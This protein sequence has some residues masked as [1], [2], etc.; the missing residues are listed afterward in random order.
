MVLLKPF[1]SCFVFRLHVRLSLDQDSRHLRT[2][3]QEV[4]RELHSAEIAARLPRVA[5]N[6]RHPTH[7]AHSA[8][9]ICA[10]GHQR[11]HPELSVAGRCDDAARRG[12]KDLLPSQ[13]NS[14]FRTKPQP[15][16]SLIPTRTCTKKTATQRINSQDERVSLRVEGERTPERLQL[17]ADEAA[18]SGS[19][20]TTIEYANGARHTIQLWN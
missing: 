8:Q 15:K 2:R 1:S 4:A 12:K 20:Q 5:P 10:G 7:R 14:T 9:A 11:R 19:L 6:P 3:P 17:A 16:V 18:R 13:L